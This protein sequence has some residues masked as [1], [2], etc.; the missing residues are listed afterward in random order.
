MSYGK[1]SYC[2]KSF[3]FHVVI[4][5]ILIVF[6]VLK[7]ILRYL[8]S[9]CFCFSSCIPRYFCL[10]LV[11]NSIS[12]SAQG[13]DLFDASLQ[14]SNWWRKDFQGCCWGRICLEAGMEYAL[15]WQSQMP[16]QTSTVNFEHELFSS[17][18]VNLAKLPCHT[19]LICTK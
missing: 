14:S 4:H 2:D 7:F 15:L 18:L 5:S 6:T 1:W 8:I 9:N 19:I 11:Y 3:S 17:D 13:T 16:L 12:I 10:F